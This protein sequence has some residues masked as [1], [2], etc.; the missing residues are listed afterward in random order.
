MNGLP[1][2]CFDVL[3]E[4]P[5]Y[6]L[7]EEIKVHL[8]VAAADEGYYALSWLRFSELTCS[9]SL[10]YSWISKRISDWHSFIKWK[11]VDLLFY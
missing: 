3:A 8:A 5:A 4:G 1:I 10:F 6:R 11:E 7:Q 2:P 9:I